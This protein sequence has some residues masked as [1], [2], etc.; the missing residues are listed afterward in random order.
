MKKIIVL[1]A[2]MVGSAIAIDL[3]KNFDIT[4]ADINQESL[5]HLSEKYNI[6]TIQFDIS[7]R[8]K[9]MDCLGN[10]DLAVCAV[11]G[12]MG[13]KTVE[14][15]I[16][17]DKDTVDI[18]FMPEDT[19]QL[20]A[21]AQKHNVTVICDCGVA[22]GMP[23]VI[24]G[25]YNELMEISHFDYCVGGL[26]KERKFPFEYKAPF[27]PIDVIEEYTRPA[28]YVENGFLITKPPMSDSELMY[29]EN[30]GDLEAFN[31]DGLRSLMFTLKHIPNMKE[32]T[33]RYPKHIALIQALK[34]AGFFDKEPIHVKGNNVVP[35]DFTSKILFNSWKL[36]PT[37]KEFT[38]MRISL[39]GTQDG[40]PKN[41]EYNLYDEFDIET[42]I[43][44]MARTTGYTATAAVNLIA[45]KLFS[46]KGVFPPEL[47]GKHKVCFDFILKYLAERNII[48]RLTEN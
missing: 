22:P 32:K 44:S 33:L 46:D 48:Y 36:Q 5:R 13:Y 39:K 3:A 29:F 28:R 30:I 2:G 9:L 35:M 20:N 25:Y 26:P 31:T 37:D 8:E 1:G 6:K 17:A 24:I 19:M 40:K 15:A 21:K 23:N 10:F 43:S 27:S 18:S 34:A 41:V 14:T 45:N 42:G 12:F 11:P 4:S 16:E 47:V 7:N 38:V